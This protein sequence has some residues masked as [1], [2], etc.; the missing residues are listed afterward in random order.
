M[1]TDQNIAPQRRGDA[2][3]ATKEMAGEAI[4]HLVWDASA[5]RL[6]LIGLTQPTPTPADYKGRFLTPEET[7]MNTDFFNA[8]TRRR[9][10]AQI[11]PSSFTLWICNRWRRSEFIRQLSPR[12]CAAAI[13][14]FCSL[15]LRIIVIAI[16]WSCIK[17]AI[18][19]LNGK[20]EIITTRNLRELGFPTTTRTREQINHDATGSGAFCALTED[21][22]ELAGGFAG[23][24]YLTLGERWEI[25]SQFLGAGSHDGRFA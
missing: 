3:C 2:E 14:L 22:S 17:S 8:E 4:G 25:W 18:G 15:S 19:A 5:S 21:L 12:V 6:S 13:P 11:M 7:G 16:D 24:R 20:A 1:N 23:R 9:R 10:V